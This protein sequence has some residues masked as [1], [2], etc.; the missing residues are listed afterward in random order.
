ML[1]VAKL[2]TINRLK[3]EI[4]FKGFII[5][6][7]RIGVLQILLETTKNIREPKCI[8]VDTYIERNM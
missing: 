3:Q 6:H 1:I 5:I 2:L 7:V 4:Y 8:N